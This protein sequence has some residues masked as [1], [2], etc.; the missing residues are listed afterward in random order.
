[1]QTSAYKWGNPLLFSAL[2]AGVYHLEQ[3]EFAY[4]MASVREKLAQYR[5]RKAKEKSSHTDHGE[6]DK[7]PEKP[8]SRTYSEPETSQTDN[9]SINIDLDKQSSSNDFRL[10][11][12]ALKLGLWFILWGVSIECGFGVVYV[13]V[14]GLFLMAYSLYGSRRKRHEPSAYSV[15]NKDCETIDGTLTAAQFERE[16][17]YGPA[18]VRH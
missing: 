14:T 1:M 5:A 13:V 6:E 17:R 11:P 12:T 3:L 18:N 2:V 16:L 15:F 8:L 10:L 4:T 7:L 9:G